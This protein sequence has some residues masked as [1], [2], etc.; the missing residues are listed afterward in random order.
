VFAFLLLDTRVSV[1]DKVIN[2]HA[3]TVSVA[4]VS[5]SQF[6]YCFAASKDYLHEQKVSSVNLQTRQTSIRF[7]VHFKVKE[8]LVLNEV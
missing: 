1:C 4:P 8:G 6:F 7:F 5:Y 2:K 3:T